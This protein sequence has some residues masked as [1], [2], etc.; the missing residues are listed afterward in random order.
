[1]TFAVLGTLPAAEQ[2]VHL[3]LT[4]HQSRQ[5]L[6]VQ[7]LEAT[8]DR[9]WSD[10]NPGLDRFGEAIQ[11]MGAKVFNL[12]QVAEELSRAFGNDDTIRLSDALQSRGNIRGLAHDAAFLSLARPD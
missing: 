12:E 10:C 5:R 8:F 6:P 9:T 2:E 7:G 4:P 3:L 1:M 11:E